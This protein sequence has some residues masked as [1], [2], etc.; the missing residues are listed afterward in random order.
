MAEQSGQNSS[1]ADSG[2]VVEVV[3]ENHLIPLDAWF[4]ALWLSVL[5]HFLYDAG[6]I[7]VIAQW[8]VFLFLFPP[9]FAL[10]SLLLI[11]RIRRSAK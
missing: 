3:R 10:G 1:D 7:L 6:S 11:V 4:S 5:I 2:E 8:P 9:G